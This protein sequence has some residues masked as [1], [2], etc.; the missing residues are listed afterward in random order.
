MEFVRITPGTFMMGQ[1][2][3]G[4]WDEAPAHEV[5]ISKPFHLAATEITNAQ[6]EA[7][8]PEHRAFR[9]EKGFAKDDDEAVVF[10]SWHNAV[11]FCAWLSEKEEKP[12][13][14]PTEAEWEYACRAGTG[15]LY[16]T[17]DSLPEVHHKHQEEFWYPVPVGLHVGM[18][19]PNPWGL[20]D[21]H[22]NVEE[23]CL[24]WYGHHSSTFPCMS[25]SP[26]G[27]S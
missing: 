11:A 24:D 13:R 26:Q 3:G 17:G 6:Y 20:H 2:E 15:T 23:W 18:A 22:G 19:P 27:T 7:F 10:V 21:M 5:T 8:D 25:W 4:D 12:Y 1:A 14:L 16:W 9:G